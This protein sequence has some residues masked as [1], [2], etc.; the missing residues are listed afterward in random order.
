MRTR[1]E[2]GTIVTAESTFPGDLLIDDETIAAVEPPGVLAGVPA[3][4]VLDAAGRFVLP[5]GIDA[6]TH[7]DMPL[8]DEVSSADDF[9]SGTIAA[10]MGGTTAIVD[11][12]TQTRGGSL[13]AA[14]DAWHAKASGR[15]VIDYGFHMIV[16]DFR[17][18]VERE[19]D[20]MVAA[21]VPSFKL[22]MAYPNRLMLDDGAIFRTLL[23]ARDNGGLV[24]LHAENGHVIEVLVERARAAGHTAPR[25]H[26]ETRPARAEA[27]AVHR[28]A[29]LAEIAGASIF[30]VHLSS[31]EALEEVERARDRGVDLFA[32]TCPQY[33]CL[34]AERYDEPDFAGAR[35][36]MSPPLRDASSQTP[37]WRG[38]AAGSIQT[39]ATDHCPFRLADKARGRDDFSRIPNGAPGIET[40][41]VLLWDEGVRTGRLSMNQFVEVT[42]TAPARLFGLGPKK[43]S[44]AVGSDADLVLWDPERTTTLSAT[45]H[46]SRADYNPYEGREVVGGP[47]AV[48]VR[49]EIV[50]DRGRFVGRPGAG[51]FLARAP[52]GD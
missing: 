10:A 43:G 20:A 9:E 16:S 4:R 5:G 12:A 49:G 29:A 24:C 45:T 19:L 47:E 28:G 8:D 25:F 52:R 41:L 3:D 1:I 39:V 44:I 50:V 21:G 30:I 22:F 51:R 33:L 18:D 32:E 46:H 27:E 48:L 40:R 6:H 13:A 17:P 38:L 42:A 7:L 23:R 36:V 11:Y 15:A 14:L 35:Y 34:S 2:N 26:A 37:L 31:A